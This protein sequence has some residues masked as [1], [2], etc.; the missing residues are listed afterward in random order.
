MTLGNR[1]N[2]VWSLDIIS[3]KALMKYV[4]NSAFVF[5]SF[6]RPNIPPQRWATIV[7]PYILPAEGYMNSRVMRSH[8][9]GEWGGS[10]LDMGQQKQQVSPVHLPLYLVGCSGKKSL[11]LTFLSILHQISSTT[12][13]SLRISKS[14][15]M[16]VDLNRVF[17]ACEIFKKRFAIVTLL[18]NRDGHEPQVLQFVPICLSVEQVFGTSKPCFF[19]QAST[20]RQQWEEV[21]QG[22]QAAAFRWEPAR[23]GGVLKC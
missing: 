23:G 12:I 16:F 17:H 7:F 15:L 6:T 21:G 2:V 18:L 10:Q 11:Q 22:S 3:L 13:I 14:L 5:C 19:W 8:A 9:A 1:Q 4:F 20:W